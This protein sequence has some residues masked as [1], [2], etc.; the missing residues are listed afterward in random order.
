MLASL[1][2]IGNG[3]ACVAGKYLFVQSNLLSATESEEMF[4]RSSV[5]DVYDITQG[6]YQVSF[7]IPDYKDLEM[8][9]FRVV[10]QKLIALS[11]RYLVVYEMNERL[12]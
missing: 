7:Y 4:S 2:T 10:G 3:H 1:P 11:G 6:L 5:V 12:P 9:D 8:T